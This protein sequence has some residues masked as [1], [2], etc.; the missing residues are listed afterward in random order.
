MTSDDERSQVERLAFL[1]GTWS[2]TDFY[3]RTPLTPDGGSG[4]GTYT[5]AWGPGRCSIV[6]DYRYRGPHGESIGHQILTWD[7]KAGCYAGSIVTSAK[8]G[9]IHVT[10]GW[11]EDNFVLRGEFDSR[12][13]RVQFTEVFSEIAPAQMMV[14]QSNSV[15]GA[16]P[17]LFG[18]TKFTR[19]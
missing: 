18:T 17:H 11:D 3:E 13:M 2:A 6:T 5:H 1:I 9:V 15:D 8:P 7:S 19:Q 12:G 4:T 16:P 14:R 10:G